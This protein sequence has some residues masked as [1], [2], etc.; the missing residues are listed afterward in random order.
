[1]GAVARQTVGHIVPLAKEAFTEFQRHKA[2]W[3]AAAIAYFTIFAIAPL[4][5]VVV[6]IAGFFLG[7]HEAVLNTLYG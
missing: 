4:K 6:E 2:H 1:L 7:Q 5:I 3:L